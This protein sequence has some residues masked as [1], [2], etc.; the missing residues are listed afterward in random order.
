M[1]DALGAQGDP[2]PVARSWLF[3]PG[4]RGERIDKAIGASGADALIL[5][6]EDSVAEVA[7][8]AA[9]DTVRQAL[10]A[11]R[12]GA[13]PQLW[14]RINPLASPFALDDLSA[15]APAAPAGIVLP[16]PDGPDDVVRL[17]HYLDVFEAAAGL[18]PGRIRILAL[19][20]E[21]PAGLLDRGDYRQAGARLTGL[22]WGAEDLASGAGADSSR[23]PDGAFTDLSRLGRTLCLA[24]AA[25]AGLPAVETVYAAFKD[26]DGLQRCAEAARREGFSGMLAIHPSQVPVINAVF[27]PSEAELDR[28]RR[29]V[30]L[31]AANPNAGALQL[32]GRM[33][34]RPHLD[35]ARRLLG[36]ASATAR[37]ERA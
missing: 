2:P 3:T 35:A 17:T 6:L 23:T 7:K 10:A 26:L 27:T 12:D 20:P 24:S 1:A 14:V 28:A 22:S 30:A 19:T 13:A 31:F 9:R 18:A 21:T 36:R 5:D 11:P 15:V 4:D 25:A 32:D 34:D 29:L 37:V 33:V 16:K 8:A